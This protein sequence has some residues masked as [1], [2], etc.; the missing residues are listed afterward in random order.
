MS[1]RSNIKDEWKGALEHY[2]QILVWLLD[3]AKLDVRKMRVN[4]GIVI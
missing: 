1:F 4:E 3:L 2:S